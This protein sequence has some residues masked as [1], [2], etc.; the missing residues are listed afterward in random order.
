MILHLDTHG[1]P[2]IYLQMIEQIRRMILTGQLAEGEQVEQVRSLAARLKVNPMTVSK[3]YAIL[4][5]DGLL[6]RRRGVGLFVARLERDARAWGRSL[7]IEESFDKAA[8]AA[9]QMGLSEEEATEALLKR[10]RRMRT[11]KG[12]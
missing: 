5:R 7:V 3:A 12:G 10:Y 6:E 1:G 11:R 9:I 8:A 4:E 2:P